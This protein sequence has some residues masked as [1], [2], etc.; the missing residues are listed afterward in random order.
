MNR[1][2]RIVECVAN[3]SEGRREDVI[4]AIASSISQVDGAWV[5]D[6]ER[7][8]DHNRSVITFVGPPE[9]VG[10]AAVVAVGAA[11]E[12]IDM[13]AHQGVH[14]RIGA[15]DVI[16]FIPVRGLTLVEC[17][18]IAHS[19]G[20]EIW[21]CY[22]IPVYLY[23]EAALL[24]HRRSLPSVR[25]GGYEGL[26]ESVKTDM[27]RFPD[28]GQNELHPT[29]GAVAVG[30]RKALIAWNID[31]ES[32]DLDAADAI[33]SAV[34]ESSGG[35]TAVRALGLP[36][37]SKGI[38]QVSMNLIDYEVT[39]PHLVLQRVESLAAGKGIAIRDSEL[40]GLIPRR[41]L[42][43][44]AEAGIDLRIRDFNERMVLESRIEA[45]GL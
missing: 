28:Y 43:L 26:R 23:G 12:R 1:V 4:G 14:P 7:D 39:P 37:E 32:N 44:A 9:S 30:A 5:L 25:Q 42:D 38:V 27:S 40:I 41:A 20:A 22:R 3:F 35:L 15:A 18:W 29:A 21:N 33:A 19:V 36:L 10:E 16:P 45:A 34:R 11:A 31:L 2:S 8:Q 6:V 13:N 17:G 24:P